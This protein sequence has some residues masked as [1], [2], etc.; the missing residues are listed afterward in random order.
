MIISTRP[1]IEGKKIIKELG[2][3]SGTIV[4]SR[5]FYRDFLAGIRNFLGLEVVEYTEMLQDARKDAV[6]RMTDRA[7][8][9]G[10]NAVLSV[11]FMT[12]P[13]SKGT[14]EIFVYGTAVVIK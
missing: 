12:S 6:A 14:S 1:T 4:R 10:A 8:S 2:M 13:T 11:K 5:I 7:Y 3:V 9:L